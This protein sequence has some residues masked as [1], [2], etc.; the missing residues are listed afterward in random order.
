MVQVEALGEAIG[1]DNVLEVV[2]RSLAGTTLP[3]TSC[4]PEA[5]SFTEIPVMS[6]F[7]LSIFGSSDTTFLANSMKLDL[8][9]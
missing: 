3:I 9:T 6:S 8:R 5:V 4:K 2:S 7:A 1:V